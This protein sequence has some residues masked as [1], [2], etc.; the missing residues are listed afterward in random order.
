MEPSA[1]EL[2]KPYFQGLMDVAD[3]FPEGEDI[4]GRGARYDYGEIAEWNAGAVGTGDA[5]TLIDIPGAGINA[6]ARQDP[7]DSMGTNWQPHRTL[8]DI[9]TLEYTNQYDRTFQQCAA[10][11]ANLYHQLI[12]VKAILKAFRNEVRQDFEYVRWGFL[13][14]LQHVGHG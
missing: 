12:E 5:D 8:N 9:Y 6:D 4:P 3:L 7:T 1:I 11:A 10:E 13:E 14:L 2:G